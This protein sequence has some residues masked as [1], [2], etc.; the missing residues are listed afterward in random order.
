VRWLHY[1]TGL[2]DNDV[3]LAAMRLVAPLEQIV[4]GSDWPYAPLPPDGDPQP[5]LA[6]LGAERAGVDAGHIARLV[7]RLW[8][9]S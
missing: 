3:A 7:P 6:G 8:S 4:F 9:G 2:A 5:A 1:D